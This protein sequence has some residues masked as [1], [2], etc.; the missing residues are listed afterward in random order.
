MSSRA[1]RELTKL[2]TSYNPDAST[3]VD[4]IQSM[5]GSDGETGEMAAPSFTLID[6][7]GGEISEYAETAMTAS[8][9]PEDIDPSK[10]KDLF[11]APSKFEGAWL[12]PGI[13]REEGLFAPVGFGRGI[14]V[15]GFS[16]L[17]SVP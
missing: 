1:I 12:I 2:Q 17:V 11:E 7:F 13:I 3:L 8:D 5:E 15:S 6:R 14:Q 10:Y 9:S 4:Q 16:S